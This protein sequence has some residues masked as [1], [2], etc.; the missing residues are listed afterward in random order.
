[1][2]QYELHMMQQQQGMQQTL[3]KRGHKYGDYKEMARCAQHLKEV[4][5]Q[6]RNPVM[7]EYKQES[8]EMICLKMARIL[9][10]DHNYFDSWHD[11]EGYAKL[12]SDR[13]TSEREA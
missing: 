13:L 12:V 9:C 5:R 7:D 4:V 1:V 11:I 10:G 8:L 2:N 6:F 3:T